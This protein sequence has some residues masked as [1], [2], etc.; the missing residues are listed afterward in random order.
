M[1]P[2]ISLVVATKDRPDDLKMLLESLRKQ[3]AGPDEIVVIDSSAR[4]SEDLAAHFPELTVRYIRHWPPSAA[5]Q[6]N[7]GVR[8][9]DSASTFIGF[10]DDDTVF[11]PEAFAHMRRFWETADP[12]VLGAS[13]NIRNCPQQEHRALKHSSLVE[14]MGLYSSKLGSVSPSGWH[15]IVGEAKESQ[16]VDWVPTTAV[17]FRR[18][19]FDRDVFDEFFEGYSYL[20]DLDLGYTI[21]RLG[22]LAIVADA[23]FK[24]FPSSS[25]RVSARTFGQYEVRNRLYF[26]RKH[27]LSIS[28]CYAGIAIR[29]AMS[30]ISGLIHRN[31]NL[32]SRALGNLEELAKQSIT[33]RLGAPASSQPQQRS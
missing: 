18:E 19:V 4:P 12:D 8:A 17:L 27:C 7:A 6:R 29:F 20:E 28:R 30:V 21:S 5:A 22:R 31:T 13:F 9:C 25:G 24:H 15:T 26:V 1:S 32:L 2:A 11:E 3:T 23:G 33:P 16:F 10:A 14:K